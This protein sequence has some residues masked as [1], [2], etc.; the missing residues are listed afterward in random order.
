MTRRTS[1]CPLSGYGLWAN[2]VEECELFS[3]S[4]HVSAR[5][6]WTQSSTVTTTVMPRLYWTWLGLQANIA[7]KYVLMHVLFKVR[8]WLLRVEFGC[9][10]RMS[11]KLRTC[12]WTALHTTG[13][14]TNV[15]CGWLSEFSRNQ[16]SGPLP[17]RVST[18]FWRPTQPEVRNIEHVSAHECRMVI[19]GACWGSLDQAGGRL[20]TGVRD[21]LVLSAVTCCSSRLRCGGTCG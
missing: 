9:A 1:C 15:F 8:Q 7:E 18:D 21:A 14:W 6:A 2:I 10:S 4:V 17:V 11:H 13:S 20:L 19:D 16:P 12:L 5:L 3:G